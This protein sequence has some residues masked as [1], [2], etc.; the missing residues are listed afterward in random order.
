MIKAIEYAILSNHVYHPDRDVLDGMNFRTL[1]SRELTSG[2]VM[3][4][5]THWYRIT[6]VDPS[7]TPNL[8]FYAALYVKFKSGFATDAVVAI[9][10]TVEQIYNNDKVDGVSWWSDV[11]GHGQY[12]ML[13]SYYPKASYFFRKAR[14]YT[15]HYFPK[16]HV[17]LTGHSLGA[18]L[19][20]LL[21]AAGKPFTAVTFNS[22]G[23]GNM[24]GVDENMSAYVT[25]IN[26]K[27][28]F[29]NK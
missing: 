14:D 24:P 27:Y 15:R 5:G 10:G 16:A 18:A 17:S 12:D 3:Q 28:G 25:G 21:V 11:L 19:A 1:N 13:P 7:L 20:Q 6:D 22:P 8:N 4:S 9:R 2:R 23:I 29:I 26:S